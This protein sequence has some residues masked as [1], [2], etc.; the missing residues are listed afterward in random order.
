VVTTGSLLRSDS[1]LSAAFG[2]ALAHRMP[3][4]RLRDVVVDAPRGALTLARALLADP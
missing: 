2:D 4:A 3:R 1:P